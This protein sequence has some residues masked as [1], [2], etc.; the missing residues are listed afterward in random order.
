M[1]HGVRYQT[2]CKIKVP[3]S[4]SI[5]RHHDVVAKGHGIA[6]SASHAGV[7][8]QTADNQG[9]DARCFE[10]LVEIG[11]GKHADGRLLQHLVVRRGLQFA[12]KLNA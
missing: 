10:A 3:R 6:G 12:V 4:A 9:L 1:Q 2:V 11:S 8:H 5:V 7:G